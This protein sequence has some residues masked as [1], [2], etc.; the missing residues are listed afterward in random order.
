MTNEERIKEL[1]VENESAG[2]VIKQIEFLKAENA[3]Y[4]KALEFYSNR[5]NHVL[6]MFSS[7]ITE[8]HRDG[9]EKATKALNGEEV[10]NNE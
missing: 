9:G 2:R 3:R 1:I 4:E 5:S 10:I 6:P 8:I 7:G